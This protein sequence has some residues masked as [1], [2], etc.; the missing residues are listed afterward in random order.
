M[1]IKENLRPIMFVGTASDVGKSVITTGF[2]RIFKQDG[3]H[4]APFKAQNMSLNSYATPEG[5]EIGRAQAVQAEACG[6]ACNTD[7]NPLLLKPV[8]DKSSQIVLHGRP[9]GYSSAAEYFLSDSREVLFSEVKKAYHRLA[10]QYSPIVL[11]GAGSISELN[12]KHR[13]VT[14]MRMAKEAGAAT[15]LVADIDRGGVFASCYGTMALLTPEEKQHIKGIIINKFRGDPEL[16]KEGRKILE[17]L[18][19]VPV[20]GVVPFFRDIVIEEEDSVALAGRRHR[21]SVGG[22]VNIAVILVDRLSNYTDFNRL[23]QDPRINLFYTRE[24]AEIGKA[25]IIILPGS[26]N[27]IED[28]LSLHDNGVAAAIQKAYAD[29]KSVIGIC[30]G[31][32][33]MGERVEDPLH[34]ESGIPRAE[35]LGLL[36]VTTVMQAEK[37]T[38]QRTFR[39]RGLPEVCQGYEIHMGETRMAD[40]ATPLNYFPDG[41]TDG[42]FLHR[43]C[44]GTYLH[45]ILDNASVINELIAPYTDQPGD[46]FD[47]RQYKEEQYDKLAAL[48]R[49]HLAIEEI[50]KTLQS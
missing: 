12:L 48:L 49:Q 20:V 9:A 32:Q 34:M 46:D 25:D 4:P 18:C 27:T 26:K 40:G 1:K 2:C 44:W 37:T 39:F 24:A 13:D 29:E 6:I 11:E 5:L 36:P 15:Y 31:Y 19:Q 47:Y 41:R 8:T 35:G 50:Y 30:G 28:L 43:K 7:M 38:L 33:M 45:G 22:K 10:G 17:E 42:Y 21:S 23:E 16:F 3:Y 14:N